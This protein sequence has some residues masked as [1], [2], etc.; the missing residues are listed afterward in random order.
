MD[1][2]SL[3]AQIHEFVKD[4]SLQSWDI[5]I[6]WATQGFLDQLGVSKPRSSSAG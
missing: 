5:E 1:H 2:P 6:T 3:Q 4:V